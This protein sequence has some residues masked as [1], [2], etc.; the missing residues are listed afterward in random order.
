MTGPKRNLYEGV[1]EPEA[2]VFSELLVEVCEIT[3]EIAANWLDANHKNRPL[4]ER[5]SDAYGR[6]VASG[7]WVLTGDTIKFDWFGRLVDGQHRLTAVIKSGR[8]IVSLV[9]WGVDPA[10]RKYTDT[11]MARQYRDVL[12]ME[13]VPHWDILAPFIRRVVLWDPPINERVNFG[14]NK[15]T[16]AEHDEALV[17]HPELHHCAEFAAVVPLNGVRI[18]RSLVAFVYWVLMNANAEEAQEFMGKVGSGA[19][20]G[21]DDPIMRLRIWVSEYGRRDRNFEAEFL[22]KAAVAWN[23]WM[24]GKTLK[25][26][27]LPRGGMQQ[28]NFPRLKTR[29]KKLGDQ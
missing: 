26:I 16:S 28:E 7:N 20:I 19:N 9:V 8:P 27:L 5:G 24:D 17:L 15:V 25:R 21:D 6:D 2:K 12:R 3:P 14:R 1:P 13:E 23:A 22:W 11:G 4:R 18:S 29:R 10:A